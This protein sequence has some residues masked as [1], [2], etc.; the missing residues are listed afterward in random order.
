MNLR[1]LT[2]AYQP[3]EIIARDNQI[4]EIKKVFDLF[5]QKG[6]AYNRIIQGVTGSGKTATIQFMINKNGNGILFSS[7]IIYKTSQSILNSLNGSNYRNKSLVLDEFIKKMKLEPKIIIIDEI[8]KVKDYRDLLQDFNSIFRQ[9]H[10]PF[11]IITNK[12]MFFKDIEEDVIKTLF[13]ESIDFPSYNSVE[14]N[15]ILDDRLK[16]VEVE[17]PKGTK[18]FICGAGAKVGSARL[19]LDLAYKCISEE[20]YSQDFIKECLDKKDKEDW[21]SFVNSIPESEKDVLKI[22]LDLCATKKTVYT[23]DVL[24]QL[25]NCTPSRLSQI[26]TNLENYNIIETKLINKGRAGGRFRSIKFISKSIFD[27]LDK[28]INC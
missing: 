11:I 8:H 13:F 28:L 10:I 16:L 5:K 27:N 26:I 24:K 2:D 21:K 20:K 12:R 6:A 15:E 7:G 23:S 18:N 9:A 14:L 3:N 22:I 1:Y 17:I 25:K 4:K 19:M